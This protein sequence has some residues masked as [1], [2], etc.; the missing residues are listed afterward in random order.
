M[1]EL[2]RLIDS[3][4]DEKRPKLKNFNQSKLEYFCYEETKIKELIDKDN[5]SVLSKFQDEYQ[6]FL[7]YFR[8]TL[9]V[10]MTLRMIPYKQ[11]PGIEFENFKKMYEFMTEMNTMMG[12]EVKRLEE[13]WGIYNQDA[14]IYTLLHGEDE[15]SATHYHQ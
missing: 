1:R 13:K 12:K 6:E 3:K 2:K 7:E 15:N 10:F 11:R 5:E 8:D 14:I 4:L 9:T